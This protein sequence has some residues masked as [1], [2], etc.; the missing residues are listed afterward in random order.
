M[1]RRTLDGRPCAPG[2]RARVPSRRAGYHAQVTYES[3]GTPA[4]PTEH[5]GFSSYNYGT[6]G[7]AS[8]MPAE[9][10]LR[11]AG[12]S[13]HASGLYRPEWGRWNGAPPYGD[14]P[15]GSRKIKDGIAYYEK[16]QHTGQR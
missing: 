8:G 14:D 2:T 15:D 9:L 13:Q 12:W 11:V 4:L 3:S 6:T 16:G 10:L 7:R 1:V 5:V